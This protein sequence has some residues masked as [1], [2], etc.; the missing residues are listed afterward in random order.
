MIEDRSTTKVATKDKIKVKVKAKIDQ[1][2]ERTYKRKTEI[3]DKSGFLNDIGEFFC[4]LFIFFL[5]LLSETLS[6]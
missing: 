1:G 4:D 6:D 2:L 5:E 3:Y